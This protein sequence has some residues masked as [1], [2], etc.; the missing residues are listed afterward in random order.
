M[1]SLKLGSTAEAVKGFVVVH[2]NY[3][4]V[5]ETLRERFGHPIL[6]VHVRSPYEIR[7][8]ECMAKMTHYLKSKH[9]AEMS[10]SSNPATPAPSIP[11]L[12]VKLPK[13][14]LPT[15]DGDVLHWQPHYQ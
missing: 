13:I 4:P 8:V 9:I 7:V 14:N 15:F 11:K 5:L 6:D 10:V 12:Q 1:R 2:E 3:Q